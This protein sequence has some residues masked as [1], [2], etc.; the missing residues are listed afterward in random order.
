MNTPPGGYPEV[1]KTI[2]ARFGA[3][4]VAST[5]GMI[6]H[7]MG[8]CEQMILRD[9]S[10]DAQFIRRWMLVSGGFSP[11]TDLGQDR[12]RYPEFC[13]QAASLAG[14]LRREFGPFLVEARS[15][16]LQRSRLTFVLDMI[17]GPE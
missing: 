8:V 14:T 6:H 7:I 3:D 9:A 4:Q 10:V 16:E 5:V 1:L 13:V 2:R 11:F 15:A 12:Q 17:L